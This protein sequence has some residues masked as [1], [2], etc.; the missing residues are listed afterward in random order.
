MRSIRQRRGIATAEFAVL[1]P[2]LVLILLGSHDIATAVQS[3]LRLERATQ[4]GAQRALADPSDLGAA[5][6]AVL[7]ALPGTT[8]VEVPTPVLACSC[9]AA[10]LTCGNPCAGIETRIITI[11]ARQTLSPWLLRGMSEGRGS[12]VLR[13]R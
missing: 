8:G 2:L 10:P 4:A 6:A 9:D 12:A 13:L 1:A 11:T 5:R 7:A 3:S